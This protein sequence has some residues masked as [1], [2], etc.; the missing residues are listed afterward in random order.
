MAFRMKRDENKKKKKKEKEK[1]EIDFF[2]GKNEA[3]K[4]NED[5]VSNDG[6]DRLVERMA[7]LNDNFVVGSGVI[8][9]FGVNASR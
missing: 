2:V 5:N 9:A 1:E 3:L 4:L 7:E 6:N 8:P